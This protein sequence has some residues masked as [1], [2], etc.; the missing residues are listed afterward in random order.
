MMCEL[1][2]HKHLTPLDQ[3]TIFH[4]DVLWF[5]SCQSTP[6]CSLNH[7]IYWIAITAHDFLKYLFVAALLG[8]LLW[9]DGMT[10]YL[11]TE[12]CW[13]NQNMFPNSRAHAVCQIIL[14]WED[15]KIVLAC[16]NKGPFYPKNIYVLYWCSAENEVWAG[17]VICVYPLVLFVFG[18]GRWHSVR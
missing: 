17:S 13:R 16:V 5:L 14:T 11:I 1:H 9:F 3:I 7:I 15:I 6:A 12:H 18:L 2:I 4:S 10:A 8:T